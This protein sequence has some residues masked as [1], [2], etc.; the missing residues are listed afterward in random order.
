MLVPLLV[1]YLYGLR[2]TAPSV[3]RG[4]RPRYPTDRRL[5]W[6]ALP[7]IAVALYFIYLGIHGAWLGPIHAEQ[8]YWGQSFVPLGGIWHGVSAA[9]RSVHQ[10][11]VGRTPHILAPSATG[12]LSDP[13]KLATANVIDL[14][15]LLLAVLTLVGAVRR[16]PLAY[17]LYALASIAVAISTV[18]PLEPLQSFPRFL[19][20]VFP[21]QITLALWISRRRWR[22]ALLPVSAALMAVFAAMFARGLWVA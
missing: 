15:F 10:L 6:L 11:L 17:W 7:P 3:R 22:L 5:A 9:I 8:T 21:C 14:A 1:I 19:A 4:A 18:E 13:I 16:L 2:V 20:V 12:A